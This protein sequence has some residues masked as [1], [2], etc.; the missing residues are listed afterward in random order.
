VAADFGKVVMGLGE[1][2]F[3]P[4]WFDG[5]VH[6]EIVGPGCRWVPPR[7]GTHMGG[8]NNKA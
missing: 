1:P 5:Q 8:I 6:F 2:R 4:A 3:F 7:E